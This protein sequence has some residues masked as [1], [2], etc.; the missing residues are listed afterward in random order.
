MS[1]HF[2]FF[3]SF[4]YRVCPQSFTAITAYFIQA[5]LHSKFQFDA[6][7]IQ[8]FTY[9]SIGTPISEAASI[10]PP[11]HLHPLY[12]PLCRIFVLHL[13]NIFTRS[14]RREHLRRG[15]ME[16]ALT[17][18]GNRS[19]S[20]RPLFRESRVSWPSTWPCFV[21]LQLGHF[22]SCRR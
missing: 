8:K 16:I 6:T 18:S 10:P 14:T 3:F 15:S 12:Y 21:G 22:K 17:E 7:T 11:T 2:I 5:K 13:A 4:L 20:F 1:F 9:A 19:F